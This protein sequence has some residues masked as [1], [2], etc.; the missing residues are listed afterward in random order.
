M[1]R[2]PLKSDRDVINR[3]PNSGDDVVEVLCAFKA[4]DG[5][6]DFLD[7]LKFSH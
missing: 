4:D 1:I 3:L 7:V 5:K 6:A 2:L